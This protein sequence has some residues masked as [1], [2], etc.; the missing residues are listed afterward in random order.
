MNQRF[1]VLK[2]YLQYLFKSGSKQLPYSHF[3]QLLVDDVI[4]NQSDHNAF[5]EI[6]DLRKTLLQKVQVIESTDFGTGADNK[7]YKLHFIS[8]ADIVRNSA[9][10]E[11]QGHLLFRLV[12]YFKPENIIELGTSIGIS[13]LYLAKANPE[14][15]IFSLEGCTTKSEQATVNFN[16]LNVNNIEQHIGRF[17]IVL[18]DVIEQIHKVDFVFMD[19]NHTY[20]ATISNFEALLGIAG[21]DT[22]F[23]FDDIHWSAGMERAWNEI[24]DHERVTI[25]IDLF[26][27]GIAFL[28]KDL[29]RQKLVIKL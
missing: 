16:T 19:G 3:I 22:V 18:P 6:R 12:E 25:S 11:R 14:S 5:K 13:T 17:D 8:I 15:K 1:Y 24:T 10:S 9:V 28:R 4:T 21:N 26:R 2:A 7:G 29:D 27:M 23:V 20:D